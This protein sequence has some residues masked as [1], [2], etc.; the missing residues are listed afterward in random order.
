MP[1]HLKRDKHN[2]LLKGSENAIFWERIENRVKGKTVSRF[3][4]ILKAKA[5]ARYLWFA[6]DIIHIHLSLV[7][8]FFFFILFISLSH[9]APKLTI[10]SFVNWSI[11]FRICEA[12]VSEN[13]TLETNKIKSKRQICV[14]IACYDMTY[15]YKWHYLTHMFLFRCWQVAGP[16]TER[17]NHVRLT[18]SPTQQ[19][20]L[21]GNLIV[22]CPSMLF[23]RYDKKNLLIL[24]KKNNNNT[25]PAIML[26]CSSL[27]SWVSCLFLAFSLLTTLFSMKYQLIFVSTVFISANNHHI[28]LD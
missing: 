20:H 10:R 6:S 25:Q 5:N 1:T 9:P 2:L 24:H 23:S 28:D 7:T 19:S 15:E 21:V 14:K 11:C 12:H 18:V 16:R 13:G 17:H 22:I 4:C 8:C 26:L 3:S 27:I